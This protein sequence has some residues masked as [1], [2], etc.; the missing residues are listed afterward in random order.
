MPLAYSYGTGNLPNPR[1]QRC[2]MG[3]QG[4]IW[5]MAA[6]NRPSSKNYI[7]LVADEHE[8]HAVESTAASIRAIKDHLLGL[9][10]AL[11][12][13]LGDHR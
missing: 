12:S 3:V 13:A 4:W 5:D 1:R 9:V 6:Q 10:A 7:D 2:M 8:P 11:R